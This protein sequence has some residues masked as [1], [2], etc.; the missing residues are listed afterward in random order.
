MHM[1]LIGA[2]E[3]LLNSPLFRRQVLLPVGSLNV[4]IEHR[5]KSYQEWLRRGLPV[6]NA[7]FREIERF[8]PAS[9]P[10]LF[11]QRGIKG[12]VSLVK[13]ARNSYSLYLH[14]HFSLLK[15]I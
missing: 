13:E 10:N 9:Y 6:F 11:G 7:R 2:A 8:R 1:L 12:T 15:A 5:L 3:L 14:N 4:G